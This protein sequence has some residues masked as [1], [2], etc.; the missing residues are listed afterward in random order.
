MVAKDMDGRLCGE[1][2]GGI[3]ATSRDGRIW[4]LEQGYIGLIPVSS[5]GT[6]ARSG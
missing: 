3:R 5:A 4:S 6:T 2:Y 1:K